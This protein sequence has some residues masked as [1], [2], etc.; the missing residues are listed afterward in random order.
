MMP[1][2]RAELAD[3]WE[4]NLIPNPILGGIA[5]EMRLKG[6]SPLALKDGNHPIN[7]T[8]DFIGCSTCPR[9]HQ[10]LHET[11]DE[12][13]QFRL[14]GHDACNSIVPRRIDLFRSHRLGFFR[15]RILLRFRRRWRGW[16][17]CTR[18]R[19]HLS[20]TCLQTRA[21]RF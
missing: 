2:S 14:E 3:G 13:F 7:N 10:S 5:L 6:A 21:M 20:Q 4:I 17:R 12:C 16:G 11:P 1:K 8:A 18:F 9:L 15:L 19:A